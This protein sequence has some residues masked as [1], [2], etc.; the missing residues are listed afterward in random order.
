MVFKHRPACRRLLTGLLLCLFSSQPALAYKKG[1][2]VDPEI[3]QK[4][5]ID[6]KKVT[7][8]DFFA[9]WCTSCKKEIPILDAMELDETKVEL[10]GVCTDK[11]I[12]K[13]KA[14]QKKLNIQFRVYDDTSQ[15]VVAAFAPFGMPA[16]YL[17]KDGIV[18]IV[19]YGAIP[20][21]DR[22]VQKDIKQLL[23]E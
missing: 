3:L 23:A 13:G 11:K 21:I 12:E 15:D 7:I 17:L 5:N 20:K 2:A 8:V 14:F 1:E 16:V 4:L 22:V 6:P 10:L 18:K 9:S 19:H